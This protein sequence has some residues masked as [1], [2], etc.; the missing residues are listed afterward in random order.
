MNVTWYI[1]AVIRTVGKISENNFMN[2][3]LW[4]NFWKLVSLLG[5]SNNFVSWQKV[6]SKMLDEL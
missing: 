5:M 2:L 6:G 3:H 4:L 1:Y